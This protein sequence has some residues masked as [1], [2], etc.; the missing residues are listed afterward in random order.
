MM[1]PDVQSELTLFSQGLAQL[2][3]SLSSTQE[4]Q[5]SRYIEEIYLFNYTY[6]LV[7]AEGREF[8]I[9]HLLDSVAPL[10]QFQLLLEKLGENAAICDLGSGAGL[11]GI[12]LAILLH[13]TPFS[14]VERSGRRAGF[15]RNAVA[16]CN[17]D[18]HVEVIQSDLS[19]ITHQFEVVTF[20]A[21]HPLTDVIRSI[22]SVVAEHG[23]VC[24]YKGKTEVVKVELEEVEALV[25]EGKGGSSSGWNHQIIPISVPYL[26]DA[27]N[28]CILQKGIADK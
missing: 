13:S 26:E 27:R 7:G 19:E 3:I 6:R 8:V 21:F 9:K 25:R 22:G 5:F 23:Y 20:R 14:L 28:L 18:P 2:G 24:A 17:L 16:R 12:P 15:L 1:M 10:A 11:P 4:N